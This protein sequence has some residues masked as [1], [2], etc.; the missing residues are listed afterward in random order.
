[1]VYSSTYVHVFSEHKWLF[2][3]IIYGAVQWRNNVK[4]TSYQS[5]Q[6]GES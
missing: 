2:I 6:Q 5:L 3:E 1:M 4:D